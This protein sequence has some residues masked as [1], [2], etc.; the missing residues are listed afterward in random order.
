MTREWNINREDAIKIIVSGLDSRNPYWEN[1]VDEEY[2]EKNNKFI[3]PTIYD[4][5]KPLGVTKEEID[6]Y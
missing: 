5:L 1:I 3:R 6:L 2:D 4:V